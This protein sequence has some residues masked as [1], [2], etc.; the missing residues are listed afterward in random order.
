MTISLNI[1]LQSNLANETPITISPG[2]Q[3]IV[4][5][6]IGKHLST[7][8]V[9]TAEKTIAS[10]G[11]LTTE[12]ICLIRN[13]DTE[14][15]VKLG[16]STGVYG[17]KIKAGE[18]FAFRLMPAVTIYAVADTAACLTDIDVLED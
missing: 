5:N 16:F 12:G 6:G 10:F 11:E 7:Y 8:V 3:T 13:T 4:K 15:F 17:I 14:N 1:S 18:T 2:S 9:G